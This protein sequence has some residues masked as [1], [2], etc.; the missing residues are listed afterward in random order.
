MLPEERSEDGDSGFG[1]RVGDG[2]PGQLV[3]GGQ[4]ADRK[5][6]GILAVDRPVWLKVIH[7][8][9]GAGTAPAEPMDE[10]LVLML[11]DASEAAEGDCR[12]LAAAITAGEHVRCFFIG[13]V[14]CDRLLW[15]QAG[16]DL[17]NAE[18]HLGQFQLTLHTTEFCFQA[19]HLRLF[20]G[21]RLGRAP[22][23]LGFQGFQGRLQRPSPD[24]GAGA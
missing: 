19:L 20:R 21:R 10:P 13:N 12:G 2:F 18:L 9:D 4:V 15:E 11:P 5:G 6:V 23:R 3:V 8:P 1:V 24:S 17:G 16:M 22:Q 14:G 7:R